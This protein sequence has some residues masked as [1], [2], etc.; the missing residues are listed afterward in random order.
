LEDWG[1]SQQVYAYTAV[2][3]F[4]LIRDRGEAPGERVEQ[5]ATRRVCQRLEHSV[6]IGHE[7][8]NR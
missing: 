8:E 5:E 7:R 3:A 1:G 4:R 6:V 2:D